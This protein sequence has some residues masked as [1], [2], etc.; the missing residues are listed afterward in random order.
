[1]MRNDLCQLADYP[2]AR[3]EADRAFD[4]LVDEVKLLLG[5]STDS[6]DSAVVK[7]QTAYMWS[8]G[9]GLATLLLDGPLEI[10]LEGIDDMNAFIH[11]VSR[12]AVASIRA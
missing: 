12:T 8:V 2:T 10:K 4:I 11:Q 3:K 9:H 7:T 6:A 5:D 1:M